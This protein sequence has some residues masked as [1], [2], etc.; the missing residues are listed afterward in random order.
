MHGD[1]MFA[2]ALDRWLPQGFKRLPCDDARVMASLGGALYTL[3]LE[4]ARG[5]LESKGSY[6]A[7]QF[8]LFC[9]ED[10]ELE[11]A[12]ANLKPNENVRNEG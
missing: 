3:E 6:P 1:E 7:K 4:A 9:G 12:R 2:V 8:A 11:A 5:R 10:T